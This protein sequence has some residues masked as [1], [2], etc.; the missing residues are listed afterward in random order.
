[1][2]RK[3]S[4]FAFILVVVHCT[5]TKYTSY[6][7]NDILDAAG[8][9]SLVLLCDTKANECPAEDVL[10]VHTALYLS[11]DLT[12][13]SPIVQMFET[14]AAPTQL[15]WLVF[16]TQCEILLNEINAFE[17]TH[18]LQGYLT[19]KYQWILMSSN[20]SYLEES[21][22]DIMNLIAIDKDRT[23]YM[24]MFGTKRYFQEIKNPLGK[25]PLQKA[26]VFPNSLTGMNNIELTLSV[27]PLATYIIKDSS[28]SYHG[29]YIELM[30]MIA[31]ELNFTFRITKP[32]DGKYG[33][34]DNGIWTG[35]IGQLVN[36]KVDV[37]AVLTQSYI[38]YKDTTQMTVPVTI[39]HNIVVYHKP[40]S[41]FMSA[42]LLVKPF[43]SIVWFIFLCS[44]GVTITVFHVSENVVHAQQSSHT[45]REDYGAYILRSTL[46]QGA[47]W[48]PDRVSTRIIFCFYS[49]NWIILTAQYTASL[50]ALLSVKKEVVPFHTMDELSAN[51]EYKLGIMSGTSEYDLLYNTNFSK[52][53]SFYQ[54]NSKL[55][56]DAQNDPSVLSKDL[57]YHHNKLLTEKYAF[58]TTQEVYDELA[59]KSCKIG[60]LKEKGSVTFDGFAFQK[61]SAYANDFDVVVS[62]IQERNLDF[63]MRKQLVHKQIQCS[64]KSQH[65]FFRKYPWCILHLVLWV[66]IVN[67]FSFKGSYVSLFLSVDVQPCA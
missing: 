13:H 43:T 53:S 56:R 57:S 11:M 64:T 67:S 5:D 25:H 33:T 34:F 60:L 50:I 21:L 59:S 46:N 15:N 30:D 2:E 66:R 45:R 55:V 7:M 29:Y 18:D 58:I 1:M 32:S 48:S 44:L 54:L 19:Y 42:D 12:N 51:N 22:G 38:R 27:L 24:A 9:E 16:C 35:M 20:T 10:S 36:R 37:A 39:G 31:N 49:F 6:Y 40:D 41:A 47:V 61:N 52:S 8:W 4:F 65:C 63:Y 26:Q 28:G 3:I 23:A 62:R 14:Y 17:E